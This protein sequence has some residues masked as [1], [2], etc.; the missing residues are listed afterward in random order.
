MARSNGPVGI[1]AIIC[2]DDADGTTAG[3][4]ASVADRSYWHCV[5]DLKSVT[6]R[7]RL[8]MLR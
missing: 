7:R 5:V 4:R 2:V 1:N 8:F 3:R 6:R